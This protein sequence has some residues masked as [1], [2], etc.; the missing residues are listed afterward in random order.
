MAQL[1]AGIKIGYGTAVDPR[2][3][4]PTYTYFK[5]ITGIPSLGSSPATQ[6][7]TTLL[8][9][10][11]VY[12]KGLTDVGG[13]LEFPCNFTPAIVTAVDTCIT[14]SAEA[15]Q[16]FAVEFPAPLSRRAYFN[17]EPSIVYNDSADIDVPLTG[18]F[19]IV[20]NSEI[21]WEPIV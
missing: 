13:A 10:A 7:V 12:I 8:D 9:M 1:S 21:K 15:P 6:D 11:H 4:A 20:P 2:V 14:A 18:V 5:D 19:A 3:S 17:G 16:E